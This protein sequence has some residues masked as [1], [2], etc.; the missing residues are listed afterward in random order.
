VHRSTGWSEVRIY[1]NGVGIPPDHLKRIFDPFFT[2]RESGTGMGL[3]IVHQI[4]TAH[5]GQIQVDSKP[6]KGSR[7]IMRFPSRDIMKIKT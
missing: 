1:D 5:G 2:T 4:V 3:A 6:G 7:F